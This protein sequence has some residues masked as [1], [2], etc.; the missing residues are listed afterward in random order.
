MN[1]TVT[2]NHKGTI[3]AKCSKSV[4]Y[5]CVPTTVLPQS[6]RILLIMNFSLLLVLI[7]FKSNLLQREEIHVSATREH[8]GYKVRCC[9]ERARESKRLLETF[10]LIHSSTESYELLSG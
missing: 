4:V 2:Y 9:I 3:T 6:R 10:V 1:Q 7:L 5:V 8:C